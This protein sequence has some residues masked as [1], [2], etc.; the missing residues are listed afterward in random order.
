LKTTPE[1]VQA[2]PNSWPLPETWPGNRPTE[3]RSPARAATL[4][5][6]Y[7]AAGYQARFAQQGCTEERQWCATSAPTAAATAT[8]AAQ[9]RRAARREAEG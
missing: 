1:F 6:Q 9:A 2:L 4:S 5:P 8:T 7:V 3:G